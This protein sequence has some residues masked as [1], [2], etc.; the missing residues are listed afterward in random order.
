MPTILY[1][2]RLYVRLTPDELKRL[3]VV[4]RAERRPIADHAAWIISRALAGRP[5]PE[6]ADGRA[7]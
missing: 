5:S 6:V 7:E 3:G 2:S 4:A 1:P